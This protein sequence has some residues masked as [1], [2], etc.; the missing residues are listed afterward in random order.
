MD[1]ALLT[2]VEQ[3]SDDTPANRGA[4]AAWPAGVLVTSP[5]SGQAALASAVQVDSRN[6]QNG[7]I[8]HS[9]RYDEPWNSELWPQHRFV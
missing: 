5:Q 6:D 2:T 8:E 7:A 1:A 4:S 3:L 9:D